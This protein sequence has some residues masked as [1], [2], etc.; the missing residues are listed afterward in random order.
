MYAKWFESGGGDDGGGEE[1]VGGGAGSTVAAAADCPRRVGDD[2]GRRIA[3]A[4]ATAKVGTDG[5]VKD[6][7]SAE[8]LLSA[9]LAVIGEDGVDKDDDDEDVGLTV[10]STATVVEEK[11]Q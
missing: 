1:D 4:E 7:L 5:S 9:R 2:D 3:G 8:S 10:A 11:E 6:R